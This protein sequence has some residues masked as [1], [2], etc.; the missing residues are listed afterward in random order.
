MTASKTSVYLTG[1]VKDRL[2][3]SGLT[4][5]EAI[6][7]GVSVPSARELAAV[8]RDAVTQAVGPLAE[9]VAALERA[10]AAMG[11]VPKSRRAAGTVDAAVQG[12]ASGDYGGAG[13]KLRAVTP[14]TAVFREP[15]A[16]PVPAHPVPSAADHSRKRGLR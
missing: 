7:L 4:P 14:G 6:R 2:A 11:E 15:G 13:R 1:E 8:V 3:A 10:V 9:R 12:L 16:D 5:G